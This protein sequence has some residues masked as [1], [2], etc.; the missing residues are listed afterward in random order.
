MP[1]P[2]QCRGAPSV[3]ATCRQRTLD[4][5]PL[6]A[7]V[8]AHFIIFLY[9]RYLPAAVLLT[10]RCS[11]CGAPPAQSPRESLCRTGWQ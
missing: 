9:F 6:F 8:A 5:H 2:P 3:V 11:E 10:V 1:R 4:G 7:G